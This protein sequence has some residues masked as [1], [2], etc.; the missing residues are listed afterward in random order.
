MDL[1]LDSTHDLDL[2]NNSFS[3]VA[4]VESINQH[5]TIRMATWTGDWFLDIRV[6]IPYLRDVLVKNPN[7]TILR[8]VFHEASLQTPGIA[9]ITNF[10][11]ELD[12]DRLLTVE[13]EGE[14]EDLET[15]R[16]IYEEMILS[17]RGAETA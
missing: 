17:Q 7:W 16:F 12:S 6:G 9:E 11:L 3:L 14:T 8:S 2:T 15:F 13:I 4:G 1:K 10:E 5:W